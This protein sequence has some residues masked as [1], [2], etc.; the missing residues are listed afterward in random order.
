LGDGGAKEENLTAETIKEFPESLKNKKLQY[1]HK[2]N[3]NK[4]KQKP[5]SR[6]Q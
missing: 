4:F 3:Q 1:S 2:Q 6:N 5:F